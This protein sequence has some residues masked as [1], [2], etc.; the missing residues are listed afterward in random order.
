MKHF[1][2]IIIF[3]LSTSMVLSISGGSTYELINVKNCVDNITITLINSTNIVED[4]EYNLT[5]CIQNGTEWVCNCSSVY[6]N[7]Q[8]NTINDYTFKIDSTIIEYTEEISNKQNKGK[9]SSSGGGYPNIYIQNNN[10]LNI[11]PQNLSNVSYNN[12]LNITLINSSDNV[13]KDTIIQ[14]EPQLEKCKMWC[15]MKSWFSKIFS[16]L[17]NW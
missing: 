6:I 8:I 1:Y 5:P 2:M 3:I 10:K 11:T 7:T 13:L 9:S 12:D 4:N 17:S 14:D 16:W 15:K